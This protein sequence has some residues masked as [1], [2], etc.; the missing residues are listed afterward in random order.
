MNYKLTAL[1]I[2]VLVLVGGALLITRALNTRTIEE[3]PTRL[4]SIPQED[5]DGIRVTYEGTSV[6]YQL[7]TDPE[8]IASALGEEPPSH[9]GEPEPI[10][11]IKDP[12]M[13]PVYGPDWSATPLLLSG[14]LTARE[15]EGLDAQTAD[16]SRY[17]LEPP[18]TSVSLDV[19]GREVVNFHMGDPT[20]DEENWYARRVGD[21][22]LF[23]ISA[24][25]ADAVSKLATEPPY[26]P[27]LFA[28]Q[29]EDITLISA[30]SIPRVLRY[31]YELRD[32]GWTIV[33][34]AADDREWVTTGDGMPVDEAA[35]AEILSLLG[36]PRISESQERDI[37]DADPFELNIDQAK[38]SV[39]MRHAEE[40]ET[41]FFLGKATPEGDY[42]YAGAADQETLY[43]VPAEWG[44]AMVRL[45]TD[46][47]FQP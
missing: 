19:R 4:F 41:T 12:H 28:V 38:V 13:T 37:E 21:N 40:E 29:V 6:E 10:W 1:L 20:P 35:W 3:Q 47:P 5:L 22:R 34:Y 24:G 11:V 39:L 23:T 17:G 7:L 27:T 15:L 31:D 46:P 8:E 14:P 16:L 26:A 25:W 30:T 9:E 36:D 2:A 32:G 18:R 33:E 44:E 45:V 42:W 43:V